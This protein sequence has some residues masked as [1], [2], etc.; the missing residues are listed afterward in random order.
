MFFTRNQRH[1]TI[2]CKE[3]AKPL[4]SNKLKDHCLSVHRKEPEALC[5]NEKPGQP[6]YTNWE[7]FIL[8]PFNHPPIRDPSIP[9]K[10]NTKKVLGKRSHGSSSETS[11]FGDVESVPSKYRLLS[12]SSSSVSQIKS[13]KQVEKSPKMKKNKCSTNQSE[14]ISNLSENCTNSSLAV[15]TDII[16]GKQEVKGLHLDLLNLEY[17]K[18]KRNQILESVDPEL[19]YQR[20]KHALDFQKK[21][22]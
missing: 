9:I 2:F 16:I 18:E 20:V 4:K 10:R 3:C 13:K 15:Q 1:T 12:M 17:N 8:D 19:R 7:S 11:G 22:S 14:Q 5:W 6:V 21:K